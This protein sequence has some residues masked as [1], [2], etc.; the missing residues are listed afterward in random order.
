MKTKS[1]NQA[2]SSNSTSAPPQA[3]STKGG[4]AP[5]GKETAGANALS[6]TSDQEP[7]TFQ[8][9]LLAGIL[10][11]GADERSSPRIAVLEARE[12]WDAAAQYHLPERQLQKLYDGL[13][14]LKKKEWDS[15]VEQYAGDRALLNNWLTGRG[16]GSPRLHVR[17]EVLPKLF[18]ASGET[19]QSR[20]EKLAKLIDDIKAWGWR[21]SF[22]LPP[23]HN[24][25]VQRLNLSDFEPILQPVPLPESP[26]LVKGLLDRRLSIEQTRWL[27]IARQKQLSRA[28]SR[29]KSSA[30]SSAKS[31]PEA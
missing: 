17:D 22:L 6:G 20:E 16:R 18:T 29:P 19:R 8:L 31:R 13:F 10:A 24:V 15:L 21:P 3:P 23:R 1:S 2:E 26:I 25:E 14:D 11:I 28:K 5:S 4:S 9:A 12:L 27:V 7:T 30:K